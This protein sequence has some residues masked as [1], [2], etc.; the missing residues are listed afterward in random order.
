MSCINST[1]IPLFGLSQHSAE[2]H[3]SKASIGVLVVLR[4][5]VLYFMRIDVDHMISVQFHCLLVISVVVVSDVIQVMGVAGKKYS[6]E[7]KR[8]GKGHNLGCPFL[9][10]LQ[11]WCWHSA[12]W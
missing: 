6:E 4:L 7:C 5:H 10:L 3:Q 2:V 12:Q 1:F 11:Q 9:T 8:Q